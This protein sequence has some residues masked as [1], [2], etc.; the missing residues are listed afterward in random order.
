MG[1]V[2]RFAGPRAQLVSQPILKEV[3]GVLVEVI[4]VDNLSSEAADRW[5]NSADKSAPVNRS[6]AGA[7]VVTLP[8][9]SQCPD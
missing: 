5:F 1:D 7:Q 9:S 6:S 2:L 8:S 3:D 4:D